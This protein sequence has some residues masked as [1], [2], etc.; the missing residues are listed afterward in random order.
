MYFQG[1][2]KKEK[3]NPTIQILSKIVLLYCYDPVA[4]SRLGRYL[5]FF[6]PNDK[7]KSKTNKE[8]NNKTKDLEKC[9]CFLSITGLLT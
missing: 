4:I 5:V 6:H 8:A 7:K 9:G 1:T 3:K 2:L